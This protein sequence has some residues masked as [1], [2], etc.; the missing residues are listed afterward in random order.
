MRTT[1]LTINKTLMGRANDLAQEH[2]QLDTHLAIGRQM[3][4]DL[5]GKI[6]ALSEE[7]DASAD[8]DCLVQ[9]IKI[10]LANKWGIKTQENTSPTTALVRYIT[11]A[12]RKTAH[13]YA[14]AIEAAKNRGISLDKF[15]G[16]IR[17]HGGIEK[18]REVGANS[19]NDPNEIGGEERLQ[20]VSDLM[21]A[22]Y[23]KPLGEF[24]ANTSLAAFGPK[25][26]FDYFI[27]ASQGGKKYRILG[28]INADRDFENRILK[29]F[30]DLI[31]WKD[32]DVRSKIQKKIDAAKIL[33]EKRLK[34]DEGKSIISRVTNS[35]DGAPKVHQDHFDSLFEISA[36]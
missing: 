2:E 19:K 6:Y 10:E 24:T 23:E 16:F 22:M 7:L 14:R 5:L 17:E 8:K 3:L 35:G 9:S 20:I 27:G 12:D 36:N 11:R 29:T 4:Y 15:P 13:V 1:Q 28:K 18:I 33:K 31:D 21:C 30:S 34:E 26:R 25:C 32:M